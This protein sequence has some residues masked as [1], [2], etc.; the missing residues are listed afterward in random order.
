MFNIII[1]NLRQEQV[2]TVDAR[3]LHTFLESKQQFADW[4]KS[5]IEQYGFIENQDFVRFHN[6]MK[7]NN[8]KTIDYHLSLDM[9]KEVS[10]VEKNEKGREARKYFI[11]CER[12]VKHPPTV[13]VLPQNF[14][15][16]LEAL[17]QNMKIS[18]LES[19]TK[20][21][22]INEQHKQLDNKDSVIDAQGKEITYLK[23]KGELLDMLVKSSDGLPFRLS[24]NILNDLGAKI[25]DKSISISNLPAWLR[26]NNFLMGETKIIGDDGK[27]I[28]VKGEKWNQPYH[29]YA[30]LFKTEI[31]SYRKPDGRI[32]TSNQTLLSLDGL[33]Y[34]AKKLGVDSDALNDYLVQKGY[35]KSTD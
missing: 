30:H 35:L 20:D 10:M 1:S 16:A 23:P 25:D 7:A 8:A 6:S 31:N 9:A 11:E 5:R 22:I 26:D 3:E 14:E 33:I 4:I 17:L 15:Q 18:R 34:F 24:A 28:Y 13:P 19:E 29:K 21:A 27:Y 2:N 12:K 32:G